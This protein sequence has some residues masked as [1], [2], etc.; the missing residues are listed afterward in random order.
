MFCVI[1]VHVMIYHCDL[2]LAHILLWSGI[3]PYIIGIWYWFIYYCDLLLF[4]VSLRSDR[5]PYIIV[6]CYCSTHQCDHFHFLT[7]LPTIRQHLAFICS[8]LHF[9]DHAVALLLCD[10]SSIAPDYGYYQWLS[11]PPGWTWPLRSG[12]ERG[13]EPPS[14]ILNTSMQQRH[15]LISV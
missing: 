2:T 12:V 1:L 7:T 6:I 13:G 15:L 8:C 5:G 3:G 11:A 10:N 14:T 9:P 4:Y